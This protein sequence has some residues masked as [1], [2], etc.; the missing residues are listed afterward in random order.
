M[1]IYHQKVF[2]ACGWEHQP[3]YPRTSAKRDHQ[4][5]GGPP[6]IEWSGYAHDPGVRIDQRQIDATRVVASAAAVPT[7]RMRSVAMYSSQP[8]GIHVFAF[9]LSPDGPQRDLKRGLKP[10]ANFDGESIHLH[11]FL[12]R[13]QQGFPLTAC[14]SKVLSPLSSRACSLRLKALSRALVGLC[15]QTY[16]GQKRLR[17]AVFCGAAQCERNRGDKA[18]HRPGA[19]IPFV[20]SLLRTYR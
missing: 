15:V 2:I 13:L 20:C 12:L 11:Q 6:T 4:R 1:A 9:R 19:V 18:W 7:L 3:F 14:R 8:C 10:M 16:R 17:W 5:D